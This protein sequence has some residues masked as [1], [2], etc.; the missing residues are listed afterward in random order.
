MTRRLI[1]PGD[2][3]YAEAPSCPLDRRRFTQGLVAGGLSA[4]LI[5]GALPALASQD[6]DKS[7]ETRARIRLQLVS[8]IILLSWILVAMPGGLWG[9]NVR[10]GA[11]Y[12]PAE[13]ASLG[14]A[15]ALMAPTL[16]KRFRG[17]TPFG[18]LFLLQTMLVLIPVALVTFTLSRILLTHRD[19]LYQ[20][21]RRPRQVRKNK[22]IDLNALRRTNP[23]GMAYR[24]DDELLYIVPP[25]SFENYKF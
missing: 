9:V 15:G 13:R 8:G 2:P 3:G 25:S 17:A 24:K 23:V 6:K 21:T 14:I 19:R 11:R 18:Q 20:P 7:I 4:P 10:Q 1:L 12:G 5:G 22:P 16:G